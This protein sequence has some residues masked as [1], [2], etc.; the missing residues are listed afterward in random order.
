M[1]GREPTAISTMPAGTETS[2]M[3]PYIRPLSAAL[4]PMVVSM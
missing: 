3:S 1:P 2:C 4:S